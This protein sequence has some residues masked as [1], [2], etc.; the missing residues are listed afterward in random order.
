[1]RSSR[2]ETK[3]EVLSA[4]A[5]LLR[6]SDWAEQISGKNKSVNKHDGIMRKLRMGCTPSSQEG[7]SSPEAASIVKE[8]DSMQQKLFCM[9]RCRTLYGRTGARVRACGGARPGRGGGEPRAASA[10]GPDECL[11]YSWARRRKEKPS[12]V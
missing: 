3:E 4:G 8:I 2:A 5:R 1:M 11:C 9:V 6:R 12:R 10:G 7:T